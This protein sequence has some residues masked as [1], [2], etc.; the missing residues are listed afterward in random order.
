MSELY[1]ILRNLIVLVSKSLL[2]HQ[3]IVTNQQIS[4]NI[5][6]LINAKILIQEDFYSGN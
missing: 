6:Q 1:S 4:L 5:N 3:Q 2:L